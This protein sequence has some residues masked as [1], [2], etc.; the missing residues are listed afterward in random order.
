MEKLIKNIEHA[1]GYNI[2]ELVEYDEGKIAS[3]T[4]ASTANSG[5]TVAALDAGEKLATHAAPGDA[6]ALVLE[7]EAEIVIDGVK[8]IVHSDEIIVMPKDIPHAVSAITKFK[9]LLILVK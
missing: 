1:K 7:G 6:M 4:L 3:L 2:K 9:M 5:I 8:H